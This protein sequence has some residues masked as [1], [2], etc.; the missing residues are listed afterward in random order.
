VS[1]LTLSFRLFTPTKPMMG[2]ILR[3][4]IP[5]FIRSGMNSVAAIMLNTAAAPY[6]TRPSPRSRW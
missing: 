5:S 2:E 3:I 6:A 4:G 1:A